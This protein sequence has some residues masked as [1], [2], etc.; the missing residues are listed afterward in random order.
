[1]ST[2]LF[3]VFFFILF[4]ALF[5]FSWRAN[6]NKAREVEEAAPNNEVCEAGKVE[7]ASVVGAGVKESDKIYAKYLIQDAI[8]TKLLNKWIELRNKTPT[9]LSLEQNKKYMPN[10]KEV[11]DAYIK[12][13][14]AQ[15]ELDDLSED[16]LDALK[17]EE[18][19]QPCSGSPELDNI[20]KEYRAQKKACFV[21]LARW[22]DLYDLTE[23]GE[24]TLREIAEAELEVDAA[25]KQKNS[26]K[27][28][29]EELKR[30]VMAALKR[31]KKGM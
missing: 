1:M 13:H 31:E 21:S 6:K 17:R 11:Q 5:Y 8:H 9:K 22:S 30:Q 14:L 16:Y 23:W 3:I 4:N 24:G 7:K 26:D 2:L 19:G 29:L 27:V 25:Y 28:R 10:K 15:L 18:L 20:R 12:L